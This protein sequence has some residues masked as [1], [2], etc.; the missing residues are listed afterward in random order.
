MTPMKDTPANRTALSLV[1][2]SSF[3]RLASSC[4]E[5]L[6]EMHKVPK[7]E[8]PY[9]DTCVELIEATG[10]I[11]REWADMADEAVDRL[12]T[13]RPGSPPP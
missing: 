2:R 3:D 6:E 10:K 8:N 12:R 9:V 13:A 5:V 4:D 7:G 11:A 1:L